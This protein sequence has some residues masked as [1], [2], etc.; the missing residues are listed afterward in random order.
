MH[1]LIKGDIN[2]DIDIR[3]ARNYYHINF[4]KVST[5]FIFVVIH[6]YLFHVPSSQTVFPPEMIYGPRVQQ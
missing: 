4:S 1:N 2:S 3:L 6:L 5:V